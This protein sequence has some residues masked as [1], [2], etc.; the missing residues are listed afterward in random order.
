MA[1]T[2]RRHGSCAGIAELY[3]AALGVAWGV[4]E[5]RPDEA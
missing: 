3:S 1:G 5:K 4:G 2:T